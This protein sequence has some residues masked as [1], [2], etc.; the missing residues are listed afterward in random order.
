M[1][2]K[3]VDHF[4]ALDILIN[5]AAITFIGDLSQSLRRHDLTMEV[6]YRAPYLAIREAVPHMEAR[7]GGAIVNISSYAALEPLPETLAYSTSKIAVEMLTL[8]AARSWP[9]RASQ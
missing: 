5:N 2:A 9:R 8:H 3:T 6:N 1:V 4:G 7:G